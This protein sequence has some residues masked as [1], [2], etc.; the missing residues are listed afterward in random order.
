M[1]FDALYFGLFFLCVYFVS[2]VTK[3]RPY[4]YLVA[5]TVFYFVAGLQDLALIVGLI[6][7]NYGVS[8]LVTKHKLSLPLIICANIG[9]LVFFKYSAFFNGILIAQNI[10]DTEIII[11]LGISFY[12]F[13]MIAYQ[14][15]LVKNRC[16]QIASFPQFCLFV[17]FFP[18]LVAGPIVRA[19]EMFTQ[20]S[21]LF[22]GGGR[23]NIIVSLGL[24]L[25]L[26]GLVKKVILSDSLSPFVDVSFSTLPD[27]MGAAWEGALLFGFQIYYD[28]SGYSDIALGLAYLL[29]IRLPINFRQ[30]YVA[31]NPQ[32]FWKKWHITLSTWIRD[33]LYIPLG[34]NRIGGKIGAFIILMSVMCVMGLWHGANVTFVVWGIGWGV[35]IAMWRY[36]GGPLK[37]FPLIS[38]MLTMIVTFTLWVVF[39]SPDLAFA[40]EYVQMMF[41]FGANPLDGLSW[42]W[43]GFV[44]LFGFQLFEGRWFN[45]HGVRYMKKINT[46]FYQGVLLGSIFLILM[47]PKASDNPFIYFR[48]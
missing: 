8:F 47:L 2:R 45:I 16:P 41:F 9:T 30:P 26:L 1:Q 31:I 39:R 3:I 33:Y 12:V 43:V 22:K 6:V 10:Y 14:V 13:Q 17:A 24:G 15:D 29:G 5:S 7:V 11:P 20:I 34:G 36:F 42:I 38:W 35:A 32:E 23:K 46:Y 40:Y 44:L 27:N 19:Q 4:I 28:F 21:R 25:C 37:R 18:Q 48:F